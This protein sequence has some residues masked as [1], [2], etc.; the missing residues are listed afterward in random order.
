VCHKCL[1]SLVSSHDGEC[2]PN[3]DFLPIIQSGSAVGKVSRSKSIVHA[4]LRRFEGNDVIRFRALLYT[5]CQHR[6]HPGITRNRLF[7][8]PHRISTC[9]STWKFDWHLLRNLLWVRW[10]KMDLGS[11]NLNRKFA[12]S[13]LLSF[14]W[15]SEY[16]LWNQYCKLKKKINFLLKSLKCSFTLLEVHQVKLKLKQLDCTASYI[17]APNDLKDHR[18]D[19]LV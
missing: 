4:Y 1:F 16:Q 6:H 3:L 11:E 7:L 8:P 18:G 13:L 10:Y 14:L 15:H 2:H 5:D 19:C 9:I 17:W 12:R